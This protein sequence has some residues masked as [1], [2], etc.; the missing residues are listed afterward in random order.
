MKD[1]RITHYIEDTG[2]AELNAIKFIKLAA[3]ELD[4]E[5]RWRVLDYSNSKI[6]ADT[7]GSQNVTKGPLFQTKGES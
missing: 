2:D 6:H 1:N 4:T 7:Y 3:E 5:A